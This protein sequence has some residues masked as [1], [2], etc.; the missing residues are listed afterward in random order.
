MD[1]VRS[2]RKRVEGEDQRYNAAANR[3]EHAGIL[4]YQWVSDVTPH[5]EGRWLIEDW[6]PKMGVAVIYGH[7]GSGKTFLAL[8]MAGHVAD[9]RNWAG[10]HVERGLVLYIIAEGQYGFDNRVAAMIAAGELKSDAPFAIVSTPIDLQAH[11]GDVE[12]LIATLRH[13]ADHASLHIALVVI[14]TLSKTFGAGKENS[15]D[16]ARYIANCQRVAATFECLTLIVH[17]PPKGSDDL[18]GHSSLHGG[19]D[20]AILVEGKAIRTAKTT[21][22]RDGEENQQV[23]FKLE[24]IAL[25]TDSRGQKV[26]TCL[27]RTCDGAEGVHSSQ[28]LDPHSLTKRRLKGHAKTMLCVI[29]EIVEDLG[30]QPP[31]EIPSSL[32]DRGKTRRVVRAELVTDKL[33]LE[34]SA[35]VGGE[36]DKKADTVSRTVRRGMTKLKEARILGSWGEWVWVN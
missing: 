22:Q 11:E 32:I 31:I 30:T 21:K 6:L 19:V 36:A 13:A 18:R 3:S 8:N 26:T 2:A 27:V 28:E 33:N 25:G 9:G 4:P 10:K 1:H 12:K 23:L 24:P 20:T 17:H 29:E 5:T 14:D 35:A 15:D 7:P 16:M 34:L